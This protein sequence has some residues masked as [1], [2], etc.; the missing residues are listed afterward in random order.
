MA[1][2]RDFP[3]P[4][5]W[6]ENDEATLFK[7]KSRNAHY[8][9]IAHALGRTRSSVAGRLD[10]YNPEELHVILAKLADDP[11]IS[12][13]IPKINR[14]NAKIV[15]KPSQFRRQK[16]KIEP[17]IKVAVVPELNRFD[18]EGI[19]GIP[20]SEIGSR[21][22]RW[23]L[24]GSLDAV[25]LYCGAATAD[26]RIRKPYCTAHMQLGYIIPPKVSGVAPLQHRP[27]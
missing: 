5:P 10:R 14:K 21:T 17:N 2:I 6:S 27:E 8:S 25:E 9:E 3:R 1:V 12:V 19:I 13:E 24:G 7:M 26:L 16:T 20:L 11:S 18:V 23:P 4:R 22:C 15:Q